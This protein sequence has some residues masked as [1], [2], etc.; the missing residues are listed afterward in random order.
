M[1]LNSAKQQ[2]IKQQHLIQAL[3]SQLARQENRFLESEVEDD[4]FA[5]KREI[6][7]ALHKAF[8]LFATMR[9]LS[10]LHSLCQVS[11]E[12]DEDLER[13]NQAAHTLQYQLEKEITAINQWIQAV[14]EAS[15]V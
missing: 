12:Y 7:A 2:A 6:H 10:L 11:L 4:H 15:I 3:L 8:V 13:F 1:S 5:Q 9:I 14:G